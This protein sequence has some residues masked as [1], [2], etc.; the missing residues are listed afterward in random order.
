MSS[1][2]KAV[3]LSYASQDAE[4]ARRICD[5]LRAAGIEVWF[6]RSA[7]RGGDAW[8]ASIRRQIRECAL[9]VPIISATTQAREEGYFR[10]EWKLAVDRSHLMA[11]DKAFLL[12]VLINDVPGPDARV[13]EEF[14]ARQWTRLPGGTPPP[15]FCDDVR[16][17]LGEPSAAQ[18]P[19][20][21]VRDAAAPMAARPMPPAS[22]NSR[23]RWLA[24]AIVGALVLL[25]GAVVA[26]NGSRL[27]G[28]NAATG[29]ASDAKQLSIV[30]LPFANLT[31]DTGQDYVSDG[32]TAAL[33]ADLSRIRG[34]FV[35]D[36]ATAQSYKGKAQTAQQVGQALGVRFVLQ[37]SVQ[38]NGNQ[39]RINALLADATNNGQ[40]WS[41]SFEGETT[42]LFALQDQVTG[43]IANTMGHELVVVAARESE[44]RKAA[45]QVADLMLRAEAVADKPHSLEKWQQVEQLT[46][47]ALA[48]D[49]D[50][51]NAMA[52][53]VTA[54]SFQPQYTSNPELERKIWVEA[55]DLARK[56]TA[57]DPTNPE[58]YRAIAFHGFATGDL[59][60]ARRAAETFMRLKPRQPDPF[61][62]MGGVFMR[63]GEAAK[64]VDMFTQAVELA[65]RGLSAV[66]PA[67]LAAAYFML[68]NYKA[69]IDWNLKAS[70]AEPQNLRVR[71]GLAQAYAMAGDDAGAR[72]EVQEV[73]RLRPGFKVNV[74][75]LRN[76]SESSPPKYRAF[77]EDKLIPAYRKAGLAD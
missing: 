26:L 62:V 29:V 56:V 47:R 57:L 14:R 37:G 67:N 68:G 71:V 27:S 16:R 34:I 35:I 3:F 19:A 15:A 7:L 49:P 28:S 8:D 33:T 2:T 40:L 39:L 74:E 48:L 51:V 13:P 11:H 76:R 6:D 44:M 17:L 20:I 72:A 55:L 70:Q 50:N 60:S 21:G 75:K 69:A 41:D 22:S 30:V 10:L 58:P 24:G 1:S 43:R 38:R 32:L 73:R 52:L 31:G 46:R 42:N 59:E 63:E 53:L 65:P 4:A 18:S 66:F 36:S 25:V 61:N 64:A 45:P 77:V 5:A 9:F 54:L 12:P 23:R